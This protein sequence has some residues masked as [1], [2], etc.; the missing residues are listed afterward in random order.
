MSNFFFGEYNADSCAKN[1]CVRSLDD[2]SFS[3]V[4]ENYLN[5]LGDSYIGIWCAS[6]ILNFEGITINICHPVRR[7]SAQEIMAAKRSDG[8]DEYR[9]EFISLFDGLS[10]DSEAGNLAVRRVMHCLHLTCDIAEARC[11]IMDMIVSEELSLKSV[12]HFAGLPIRSTPTTARLYP[13]DIVKLGIQTVNSLRFVDENNIDPVGRVVDINVDNCARW[14]RAMPCGFSVSTDGHAMKANFW[15][16][17]RFYFSTYILDLNGNHH[18]S[19]FVKA[20]PVDNRHSFCFL[21]D[22]SEE[23]KKMFTRLLGIA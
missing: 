8:S 17:S 2:T 18:T 21:L 1:G 23:N 11:T 22:K 15:D 7:F 10:R 14:A 3:I 20:T 5:S 13:S 12:I 9:A 16:E 19:W 6:S 4:D